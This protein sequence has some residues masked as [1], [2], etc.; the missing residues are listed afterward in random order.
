MSAPQGN[1]ADGSLDAARRRL[2]LAQAARANATREEIEAR[3]IRPNVQQI[4]HHMNRAPSHSFKRTRLND[5]MAH[6][7]YEDEDDDDTEEDDNSGG[8]TEDDEDEFEAQWQAIVAEE[9]LQN[10]NMFALAEFRQI[11]RQRLCMMKR[12][13]AQWQSMSRPPKK[14]RFDLLASLCSCTELIVEVCKHMRP[15]DIVRLYSISKDFH[16]TI[17]RHM[18][19]SIFAWASHMAPTATRIYSSPVYCRWFI[20]DPYQRRVTRDDRELSRTQPGQAKVEGQPPLNDKEGEI[21]LIPGLLWLQMVVNREIRV[22]DIIA[23]MARKGHRLPERAHLTLK[24]LWLIM[25]AATTQARMM[26][27]NNPDFFSNEDL[28]IAQLFMIKLI[29]AF[30]DPVFGP[31]SSMLM[32]LML[33]QRGLSPLWALL[34]GKKYR[35]VAEIRR[36]KLRYDV[37]PDQLQDE[38]LPALNGVEVDQLGVVHFE[39]WGTGPDHL[40]RPDELIPLEAARRQLDLDGCVDEMMIYGHVDF[41]TGNSLVPSLDE[42]YMSD[43]D[44]PAACKGWKPLKHELIHSGCGNVPFEPGMWQPKHARKA[45]WKTLT[46]EEKAMILEAEQEEMDEVKELD[47]ARWQL[48]LVWAKLANLTSQAMSTKKLKAKFKLLDPSPAEMDS[49]LAQ[50][51][52]PQRLRLASN[53]TNHYPVSDPASS[54]SNSASDSDPDAMDVDPVATTTTTNTNPSTTTTTHHQ[55]FSN[56]ALRPHHHHHHPPPDPDDPSTI[57]DDDL[58]LDPIPASEVNRIINSFRPPRPFRDDSDPGSGDEGE[59]DDDDDQSTPRQPQ[60]QQVQQQPHPAEGEDEVNETETDEETETEYEEDDEDDDDDELPNIPIYNVDPTLVLH[61]PV[62]ALSVNTDEMLLAQADLEYSDDEDS[63]AEYEY[64]DGEGGQ[65]QPQDGDAAMMLMGDD[66]EEEEEEEEE[67]ANRDHGDVAGV[68]GVFDVDW[69]DFLRNPGAYAIEGEDVV[70][71]GG[72][73]GDDD[74]TEDDAEEIEE[75]AGDVEMG[76]GGEDG[77]VEDDINMLMGGLH[78]G[79]GGPDGYQ[80]VAQQMAEAEGHD[81]IDLSEYTADEDVG[82]DDRTRKLRDWFRPW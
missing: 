7:I 68:G 19:S 48:D 66:E 43:D 31:Q 20:P 29:L 5:S 74:E 4:V 72:E 69:D 53:Y 79:Q 30:N 59:D 55:P 1:G 17:N 71:Q 28:Y 35:T 40:L 34:R 82:E 49:Q 3:G 41:A 27:L 21:R 75:E 77:S 78:V 18:R 22:R 45:R 16:R 2:A 61:T 33:G 37:G 58:A 24:K 70:L 13:T 36:L 25:D 15:L 81:E 73:G 44:L 63:D 52:R 46:D 65:Q 12:A 32:R 76:N 51:S 9:G 56:L 64:E 62:T 11:A 54:N 26:L 10:A 60:N 38:N 67:A 39:G 8:N 23:C 6:K 47:G 14:V 50:F 57:P 42:M 80:Q